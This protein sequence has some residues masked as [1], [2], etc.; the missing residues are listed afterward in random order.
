MD[1]FAVLLKGLHSTLFL[2]GLLLY[3]RRNRHTRNRCYPHKKFPYSGLEFAVK[4]EVGTNQR[5]GIQHIHV[6]SLLGHSHSHTCLGPKQSGWLNK[7]T[8]EQNE[9]CTPLPLCNCTQPFGHTPL[10]LGRHRTPNQDRRIY[11]ERLHLSAGS[12]GCRLCR[13]GGRDRGQA[14]GGGELGQ[15]TASA[16]KSGLLSIQCSVQSSA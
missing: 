9:A 11:K 8:Q 4:E 5:R 14:A 7:S 6:V 12:R 2:S 15:S 16:V 10:I 3:C 1:T 13:Q